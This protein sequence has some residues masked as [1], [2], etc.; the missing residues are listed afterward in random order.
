MKKTILSLRDVLIS[1]HQGNRWLIPLCGFVAVTS[2]VSTP[3]LVW[4]NAKVLDLGIA[5]AQKRMAFDTYIIYLGLFCAFLLIPQIAN[6]ILRSYIE[7]ESMLILRTSFKGK[8]LQKLKRIRY[9][10][11]ESDESLEIIAKAYSRAEE[12]TLHIFPSYFFRFIS[13]FVAVVGTLYIFAEICWW[14][15]P[16]I[17]IPFFLDTWLSAKNHFN[18]YNEMENYWKEEHGS[19][20]LGEMLKTREYVRENSLFGSTRY[21]IKTYRER[22]HTRNRKFERFYFKNL[23]HHFGQQNIARFSAL[24]NALLLL[25][26]YMQGGMEMGQ[27]ISMT[28]ALFTTLGMSLDGIAS[29]LK[30]MAYQ[31]KFYEYY[32][33]YFALSEDACGKVDDIPEHASIE[34]CDVSFSYPGSDKQVLSHLSFFIKAGERVAIVGQNGEGK[35]TLIKLLLGLYQPDEGEIR[36][37]GLPLSAYSCAAKEKLF[38]PVFQDFVKY[39]ITLQENVGVGDVASLHDME[40]L[41]A[42]MRKAKV[43]GLAAKLPEGTQ[44]ILGRNFAGGVDLSGGEWQRVAIARAFMGNKPVMILDEPTSQLDPM[45]ESEIYSDFAAMVKGKTSIFITH[46]LGATTITDRILVLEH[47]TITQAGTHAALLKESGLYK[48][49]FEA[50]KQWYMQSVRPV[51]HKMDASE[52]EDRECAADE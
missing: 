24:F 6:V 40:Q 12:A 22:M 9:E 5:V 15:L 28:L 31:V 32:N 44:T 4:A 48:Q 7:P 1:I 19:A 14:L 49:M 43:D 50:Q 17:V 21:L 26:I 38:A 52:G 20:V 34:F 36:V 37:G 10:H 33:R 35:T 27:L 11:F 16:T 2:G 8:M 29:V 47:G 41:A 30:G 42:A 25:L 45:A 3:L 39:D 13:S 18:I 46:R 51:D 23:K